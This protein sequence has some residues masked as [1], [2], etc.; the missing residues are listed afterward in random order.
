MKPKFYDYVVVLVYGKSEICVEIIHKCINEH[1]ALGRVMSDFSEPQKI[2]KFKVVFLGESQNT[3]YDILTDIVTPYLHNGEKIYAIKA[4]RSH[5][6]WDLKEAKD[7]VDNY[8]SNNPEI[9]KPKCV[10]NNNL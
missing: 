3:E 8:C 10:I 7:W 9:F 6:N 1:E 2:K 5:M 4:I